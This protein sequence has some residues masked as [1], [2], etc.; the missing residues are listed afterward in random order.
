MPAI[1]PSTPAPGPVPS[2]RPV[3]APRLG[4][5][6]P[7]SPS[8]P[9]L[10]SA[11]PLVWPLGPTPRPLFRALR[12]APCLAPRPRTSA[13]RLGLLGPVYLAPRPPRP[14]GPNSEPSARPRTCPAPGPVPS[15]RLA[16][17][18]ALRPAPLFSPSTPWPLALAPR[19]GLL[20]PVCLAPRPLV[21]PLGP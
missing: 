13:P 1:A 17:Y 11:R 7:L 19:L 9:Y 5:L 2:P 14:L 8:A 21:C 15:P 4:L 20:G 16:P 6:G 12:P 3:D 18:L 10:P